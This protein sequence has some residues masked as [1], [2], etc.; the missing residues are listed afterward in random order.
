MGKNA[1]E[2]KPG[3][4]VR[5]LSVPDSLTH[6]LPEDERQAIHAQVGKIMEI[7]QVDELHGYVWLGF[8]TTTDAADHSTYKGH[9][10]SIGKE[11]VEK[12]DPTHSGGAPAS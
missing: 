7:T 11:H 1:E 10:F 6:D 4:R 2:L 3:D 8:G 5:L 12:C 9:S